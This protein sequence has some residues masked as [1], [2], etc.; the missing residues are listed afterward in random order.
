MKKYILAATV[1]SVITYALV[2]F[3]KWKTNPAT[4]EEGGRVVAVFI[5]VVS[6]IIS[7]GTITEKK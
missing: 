2:T 7:I 5:A 3:V 4:W 1:P 6:T